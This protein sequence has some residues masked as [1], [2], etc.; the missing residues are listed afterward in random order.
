MHAWKQIPQPPIQTQS[1]SY[2]IHLIRR[3]TASH[4]TLLEL[5]QQLHQLLLQRDTPER[6]GL[7]FA[8]SFRAFEN[9]NAAGS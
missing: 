3:V 5:Q 6:A 4:L 2:T 9:V 7:G 1:S 8:V